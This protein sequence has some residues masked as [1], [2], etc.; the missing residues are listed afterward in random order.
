MFLLNLQG[1]EPIFVQI[2]SQVLQFIELGV[3]KPGDKLPSVRQLA[4][5]NGINPNTVAKA[6]K[7][8]E[9]EGYIFNQLKRGAFVA[10]IDSNKTR[11]RQLYS[12]LA[13]LRNSKFSK[14]EIYEVLEEIYKEEETC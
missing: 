13:P 12:V 8:L 6:Y 9:N 5:D 11:R 2:R 14:Q 4:Q 7:Q 1:K 3:L 10:E